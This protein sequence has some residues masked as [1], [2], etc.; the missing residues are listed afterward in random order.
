MKYCES[1]AV[2]YGH[3]NSK[4]PHNCIKEVGHTDKHICI[5]GYEWLSEKVVI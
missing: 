4:F 1:L 3:E 5:C 2:V